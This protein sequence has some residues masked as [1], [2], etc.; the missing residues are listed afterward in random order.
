[1]LIL[2]VTM[3]LS[4]NF[5]A[6]YTF[7]MTDFL[8]FNTRDLANFGAF[9]SICLVIGLIIYY[10]FLVGIK[11]AKLYKST[12]IIIWFISLSFFLVV[13]NVVQTWGLDVKLFCMF[14]VGLTSL[15]LELNIMPI[16][17]IWSELCP[18]NLEGLSITL[19]TGM[20]NMGGILAEYLGG[21][22]IWMMQ[23]NK[24][25][26]SR[27]WILVTIENTYIFFLICAIFFIH[28]PEPTS[29]L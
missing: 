16:L 25:D 23:F 19:I 10:Y 1:M 15:I 26:F 24:K 27:V 3:R 7:Y 13:L 14:S 9:G 21:F 11:P 6:M 12:T 22:I 29:K 8:K 2:F 4:P 28:F 20:S 18:N 5:S 17:A